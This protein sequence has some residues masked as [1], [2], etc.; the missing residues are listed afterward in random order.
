MKKQLLFFFGFLFSVYF[1]PAQTIE[2]ETKTIL[3]GKAEI[4]IPK[5]F[6]LMT[7]EVKKIK[8]PGQ[9]PPAVVY[10]NDDANVNVAFN[11][12]TSRASQELLPE[13]LK[14]FL[15]RF[16]EVHPN[17]EWKGNGITE[18][19]GRKLGY[20]ELITEAADTK[21]YNLLFFTDVD[22]KLLI[23]TFNSVTKLLDVWKDPA[24]QI[25]KSFKV[26]S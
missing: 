12:T 5:G 6:T 19:N 22:G 3:D 18:V 20:L 1:L 9:N 11:H 15:A 23:C 25:F 4:L 26:K 17:A 16:K 24:Q 7:D 13:Y 2:L 21:V 14:V 10:T 8:Y